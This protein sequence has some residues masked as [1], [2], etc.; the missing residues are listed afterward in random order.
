MDFNGIVKVGYNAIA[1]DYL[2]IRSEDS[3]DVV[4]L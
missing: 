4:L 1:T 2:G 3:E